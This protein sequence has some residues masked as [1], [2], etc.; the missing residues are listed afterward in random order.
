VGVREQ[1]ALGPGDLP[2]TTRGTIGGTVRGRG[3]TRVTPQTLYREWIVQVAHQGLGRL[4]FTYG[5]LGRAFA[6]NHVRQNSLEYSGLRG[7]GSTPVPLPPP[8]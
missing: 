2:D 7:E 1:R 8:L 4:R 3:V 5:G 6:R